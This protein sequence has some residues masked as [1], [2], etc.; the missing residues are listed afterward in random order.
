M[1]DTVLDAGDTV[2]RRR[3]VLGVSPLIGEL[4]DRQWTNKVSK[5]LIHE[6]VENTMDSNHRYKTLR[7]GGGKPH[8]KGNTWAC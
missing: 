6:K 4:V 1:K 2:T 3:S 7:G 5:H 8:C